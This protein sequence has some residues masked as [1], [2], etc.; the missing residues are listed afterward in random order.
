MDEIVL[1][2]SSTSNAIYVYNPRNQCY[3]KPVSYRIDPYRL[4]SSVYP[5]IKYNGGLF[6]SLHHDDNRT[7][8]IP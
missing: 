4:P 3:N 2:Q 8:D 6:V 5:T 7:R 1:D